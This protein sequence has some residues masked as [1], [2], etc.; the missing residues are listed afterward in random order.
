MHNQTSKAGSDFR[1]RRLTLVAAVL[2]TC[3]SAAF[4]QQDTTSPSTDQSIERVTIT[5]SNLHRSDTET[6]SP[7]Q[8]LTIEEIK[9]SGY[10]DISDVLHN[11][12]ANGSGTLSNSFGGAFAEGASGIALRGL[13]VGATLTLVDGHRF[14][15]NALSDDGERSFVD[16]SAIPLEAIERIEILKDGASSIYGSDAIAGVINIILKKSYNGSQI[17]A[18]VGESKYNDAKMTHITGI[19]GWGDLDADGHNAYISLEY[20]NEGPALLQDRPYLSRTDWSSLTGGVNK[21]PGVPTAQNSGYASSLTGYFIDPTSG[22]I[23][24][25]LPGCNSFEY[26]AGGCKFALNNQYIQTPTQNIDVLGSYT[27]NL[28]GGWQLNTKLSLFDEH[29]STTQAAPGLP[30][31][32][33]TVDAIGPGQT[34][35]VNG[36]YYSLVPATYPGNTTG[37]PQYLAASF[38]SIIPTS[39]TDSQTYRFAADLTGQIYGFD[40]SLAV[41]YSENVIYVKET[42]FIDYPNMVAALNNPVNP[43][44][45]GQAFPLN[46]AATL[47][48]VFPTTNSREDD[49]LAYV[50]GTLSRDVWQLP[51]GPLGIAV[52]FDYRHQDLDS[53]APPQYS[54]GYIIGDNEYAVGTQ[55]VGAVFGEVGAPIFKW[56]EVDASVRYDSYSGSFADTTPKIGFKITPIDQVSFRGTYAEGFR[57]PN[58]AEAGVAGESFGANNYTDPVLCPNPG[59]KTGA[60]NFPSACAFPVGSIQTVGTDLQPEKSRSYTLGLILEPIKGYSVSLDYY[61]IKVNNQIISAFEDPDYSGAIPVRGPV[62]TLPYNL[63]N[64]AGGYTTVQMVTPV[65]PVAY[66]PY[67]YINAAYTHTDGVDLDARAKFELPYGFGHVTADLTETHIF[68]YQQAFAGGTGPVELA[69]THGPTGVSGDTG[70]PK[71]RAQFVFTYER[72]PLSV[73]STTTWTAGYSLIDPS[74]GYINTCADAFAYSAQQTFVAAY[75]TYPPQYC[76]VASSTS[77]DIYVNYKL[78]KQWSIHGS[79]QNLFNQNAPYDFQTYGGG[80]NGVFPPYQP[81]WSQ[82]QALGRYFTVGATYKF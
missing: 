13:T 36:P 42:G 10:T 21:T 57:A 14:V 59:G 40:A 35:A 29:T 64:G 38:G 43:L 16:I 23:S 7:V 77:E 28:P 30:A 73:T 18:D 82:A 75:G 54:S 78:T 66:F 71:D 26:N 81:N 70:N 37:K 76:R 63:P 49:K 25:F 55:N 4:A 45:V 27:Q 24:G 2:A 6:P 41:G 80:T 8:V 5:G 20:R 32:G 17:S 56:A 1:F 67:P 12:T 47:A 72:G 68:Q 61:D 53:V 31:F 65:G 74:A 34:P 15:P 52:G 48:S 50:T 3:S 46:S 62:Q 22:A 19:T 39:S 44:R 69:G 11:L 58:P 60:G 79:I 9:Q 33:T 51:G